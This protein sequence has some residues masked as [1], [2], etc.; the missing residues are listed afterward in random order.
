MPSEYLHAVTIYVIFEKQGAC[1]RH[2]TRAILDKWSIHV[3]NQ[4]SK[5]S[6]LGVSKFG[7]WKLQCAWQQLLTATLS[8]TKKHDP[9]C[10]AFKP[11]CCVCCI[12]IILPPVLHATN[13]L[14]NL[15]THPVLQY[16]NWDGVGS[17]THLVSHLKHN[18]LQLQLI[19]EINSGN[20]GLWMA[21]Q[22][23]LT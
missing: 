18:I 11:L 1:P 4:T 8:V 2:D 5:S 17:F 9:P 3:Q 14:E 23:D 20:Q 21:M 7:N 6:S 12:C 22:I 16:I 10:N 15:K 19:P 13:V